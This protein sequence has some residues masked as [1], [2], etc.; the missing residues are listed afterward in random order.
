MLFEIKVDQLCKLCE[1]EFEIEE[2]LYVLL[3][4]L[5]S[6]LRDMCCGSLV[7]YT[8]TQFMEVG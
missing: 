4:K 3:L 5:Q 2:R 8:A 6:H 7:V 1:G